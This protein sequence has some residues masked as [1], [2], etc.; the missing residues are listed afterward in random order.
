MDPTFTL[1]VWLMMGQLSEA[2]RIE[3]LTRGECVELL[4]TIEGDRAARGQCLS[5]DGTIIKPRKLVPHICG[6]GGCFPIYDGPGN[7]LMPA[8]EP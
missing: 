5:A 3:N 8:R 4:L 1:V 2:T 7:T 6:F